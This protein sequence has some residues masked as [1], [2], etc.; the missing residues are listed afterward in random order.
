M[1]SKKDETFILSP[2]Q[3]ALM[4]LIFF[5]KKILF[6]VMCNFCW[7]NLNKTFAVLEYAF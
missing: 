7:Y 4:T 5:K 3:T 2:K 1:S 6:K